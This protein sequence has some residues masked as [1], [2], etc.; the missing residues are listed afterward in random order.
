MD[1]EWVHPDDYGHDGH[2]GDYG[3]YGDDAENVFNMLRMMR[4]GVDLDS[5]MVFNPEAA[6]RMY[7]LQRVMN[8]ITSG[9]NKRIKNRREKRRAQ[10]AEK[11]DSPK[12]PS[13]YRPN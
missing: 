3:D 1:H 4:D 5:E 7:V 11:T 6:I 13:T 8:G 9:V 12:G 10:R 2:D